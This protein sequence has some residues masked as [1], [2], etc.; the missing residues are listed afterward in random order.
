MEFDFSQPLPSSN[1]I[2]ECRE[3]IKALWQHC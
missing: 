3:T 1:N 2:E